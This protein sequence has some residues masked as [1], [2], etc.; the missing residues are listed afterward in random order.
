MQN[1]YTKSATLK[2]LDISVIGFIFLIFVLTIIFHSKVDNWISV[3]ATFLAGAV[4]YYLLASITQKISRSF[5]RIFSRS[6]LTAASTGFLFSEIRY[7]QHIFVDGWMDKYLVSFDKWLMGIEST[8][9]LQKIT[10]PFVTEGMMFAYTVYVPLIVLVALFCYWKSGTA[11]AENYMLNLMYAYIFCYIWFL[12]FPIAG[13]L[14]YQPELYTVPLKGGI[15]TWFGE[16]IRHNAHYPGGNFPSPH[17]AAGTVMLISLYKYNRKV[18]YVLLPII[19]LLY[20]STVYGR[21]HFA[22]DGVTGIIAAFLVVKV[23]PKLVGCF[24]PKTVSAK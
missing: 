12:L 3:A 18:F 1:N 7:V 4:G 16:W 10:V 5:W 22:M 15:F 20:I 13:P 14:F 19:I 24:L 11:G 23:S 9:A 8:I 6:L 2:T 17:C 21:Y